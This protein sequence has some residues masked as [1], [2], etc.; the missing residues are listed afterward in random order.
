MATYFD[1]RLARAMKFIGQV[2][3]NKILADFIFFN[4]LCGIKTAAEAGAELDVG[5]S[6]A[7]VTTLPFDTLK[8]LMECDLL[9]DDEYILHGAIK[10]NDINV[11]RLVIDRFREQINKFN[12]YDCSPLLRGLFMLRGK[13]DI[14]IIKLLYDYGAELDVKNCVGDTCLELLN[15]YYTTDQLSFINKQ[16]DTKLKTENM[17]NDLHVEQTKNAKVQAELDAERIEHAITRTALATERTRN[18]DLESRL[19]KIKQCA[20]EVI[21]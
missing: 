9:R 4:D 15:K 13:L 18:A 20:N 7:A 16:E 1:K 21:L 3:K 10:R 8:V 14:A 12:S 5:R 6:V 2:E 17:E 19:D 11:M